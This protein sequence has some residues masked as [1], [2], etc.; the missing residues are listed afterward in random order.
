M[1]TV[2]SWFICCGVSALLGVV[3]GSFLYRSGQKDRSTVDELEQAERLTDRALRIKAASLAEGRR[4]SPREA[5]DRAYRELIIEDAY[6]RKE[7]RP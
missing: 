2:I 5:L 7:Y 4:M 6:A 1:N 3:V